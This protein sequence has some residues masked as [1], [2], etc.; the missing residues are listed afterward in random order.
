M[1]SKTICFIANACGMRFALSCGRSRLH[2]DD[3]SAHL[4]MMS[5]NAEGISRLM[6]S[7]GR[8][9]VQYIN[10]EYRRSGTLWEGN[11]KAGLV[12]SESYLF[13]MN[14]A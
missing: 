7:A 3:Q 2:L 5:E 12:D 14:Y 4:L 1:Q 9:C 10:L 13:C 8:R 6:Q 11:H